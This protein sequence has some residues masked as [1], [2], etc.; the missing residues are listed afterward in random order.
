VNVII[1]NDNAHVNGGAAKVAIQEAVGLA[2]RGHRICFVCAVAPIAQELIHPN[3]E[4]CC[5]FQHDLKANPNSASAFAQGWWNT[6][7]AELMRK[8]IGKLTASETIIHLHVWSRALSASV[9]KVAVD[10]R[11]PLICTLHDFILACPSG[12]FFNHKRQEICELTPLSASCILANCDTRSY[13]QKLWRVGRQVIQKHLCAAPSGI[14]HVITHS[15][16]AADVMQAYLPS[17]C[18]THRLP[19]YSENARL[20]PARP[21]RT[22][23]L[24]YLGRLVREKGVLLAAK[25]AAAEAMPIT[26]VGSGPLEEQIKAIYSRAHVT[27]WVDH[28]SSIRFVRQARALIFPSL[29]YETL[30][31]VV[32]EAAAHGIPSLVP[33]RSAARELV[34]DGITGLHFRSGDEADLRAKLRQLQDPE[35]VRTLG[36]AAYERF[37][38]SD[39]CS[40]SAHISWLEAIYRL[41]FEAELL[42]PT[43]SV[44]PTE[45]MHVS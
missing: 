18:T 5:T 40:L 43:L 22:L 9:L 7:A 14:R 11:L 42:Q 16:L 23:N 2:Q 28:A 19:I 39:Y 25:A 34:L 21:E 41:V 38:S 1:V 20:A 45:A 36:R 3:I 26:F 4:I 30:G 13:P 24:V 35:L 44:L 32:L 17:D 6:K 37:W 15:T 31:L 27:G 29:W 10:S 8:L 33:D 12:T